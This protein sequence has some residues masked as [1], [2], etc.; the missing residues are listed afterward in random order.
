MQNTNIANPIHQCWEIHTHETSFNQDFDAH[1]AEEVH[2][3]QE[4]QEKDNIFLM[5]NRRG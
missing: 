5:C 4:E 3:L 1:I 2:N